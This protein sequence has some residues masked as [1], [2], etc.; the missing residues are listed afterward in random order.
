MKRIFKT[1]TSVLLCCLMCSCGTEKN[2]EVSQENMP[3]LSITTSDGKN[4]FVTKPVA[5]HVSE[6]IASWTPGYVMPPEPYYEE[7]SITLSDGGENVLLNSEKARVK[8]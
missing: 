3:V 1:V 5:G 4:D 8:V 6:Q 2:Q 7:C